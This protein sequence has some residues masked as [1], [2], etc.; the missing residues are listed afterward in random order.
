M[1]GGGGVGEVEFVGGWV[2]VVGCKKQV[3]IDSKL[4]VLALIFQS[5]RARVHLVNLESVLNPILPIHYPGEVSQGE[6]NP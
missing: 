5:S 4:P 6:N 2:V 3:N 1:V